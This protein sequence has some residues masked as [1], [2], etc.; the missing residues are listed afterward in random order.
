MMRFLILFIF[1]SCS[2]QEL[3]VNGKPQSDVKFIRHGKYKE[4]KGA[5]DTLKNVPG[6]TLM[7]TFRQTGKQ[8]TP[9][10]LL[11]FSI[12]HPKETYLSRAS[13]RIDTDGYLT[14]IARALDSEEAQNVRAKEKIETGNF[15]QAALVIDYKNDS[16]KLYLDGKPL[17]SEGSVAFQGTTTSDTPSKSVSMGAEDDGSNFYFQGELKDPRVWSRALSQEEILMNS[18][19]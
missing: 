6:A 17:E 12:G 2:H 3:V 13:I 19:D 16:M 9:Q 14:G 7:V 11:S 10:D 5:G 18:Q 4:I 1:V 15:H 8:D